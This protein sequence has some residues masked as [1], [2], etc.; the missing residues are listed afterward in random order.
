MLRLIVQ[1]LGRALRIRVVVLVTGPIVLLLLVCAILCVLFVRVVLLGRIGLRRVRLLLHRLT[2][3][4]LVRTLIDERRR[5][6]DVFFEIKRVVLFLMVFH[7]RL[8]VQ[9]DLLPLACVVALLL[10]VRKLIG[11]GNTLLLIFS[12]GLL[13]RLLVLALGVAPSC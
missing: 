11:D 8:L 2:I 12:L 1:L 6:D 3:G 10:G 9:V 5:S 7:R 13:S 4:F